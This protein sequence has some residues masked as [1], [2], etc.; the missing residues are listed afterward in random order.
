MACTS[1]SAL[2]YIKR[3]RLHLVRELQNLSVI[4]ENLYQQRVLSDE[5]VSKIQAEV[6]DYNKTRRILDSVMKNGEEACYK[7]LRIIDM[8]RKRAIGR[9]SL[10]PDQKTFISTE[11]KK[12]DLHHWISCFSFKEETKMETNYLQGSKQSYRYQDYLKSKA[13]KISRDFWMASKN[14]FEENKPDLSY[15]SLVL[16]TQKNISPSKIKILKSKKSRMSRPKKLKTY[17]PEDKPEISPSDLLKTDKNILLVGKPG[18][19]KTALSLEMFKVWAERDNE[20]L[21]Y[22]FYFD[23]R[24]MSETPKNLEDLLFNVFSEPGE[25]KEEV[26]QD[27]KN[28]V[29]IIFDGVTDLSSSVVKKLVDKDLLPD[30][31]IIITCRPEDEEDFFHWDFLRVEVKGFSEKTIKT[32]LSATLGEEQKKVSSNLEL[33]TLCHVP[34]YALMVAACF[35]SQQSAQPCTVTE[36]YIN[37]V[38]LSLQ[39]NSNRS[40]TKDLNSF[41]TNK[42]EEILS[43]AQVAFLATEGKTVNLTKLPCEDIC[44]LSFLKSLVVKVA[45]TET[46]TRYAFLHYTIQEFFAAVWLLKNPDKIKE[47]FQQCLT[48]DKKH[49]KHLIPFMC[50]LLNEKSPT[51]MK[52][53]I[54]AQELKTTSNWFFKEAINTFFSCLCEEEDTEDSGPDVDILFLCQCLYESQCPE[55]CIYFLEKLEY[56]LDLSEKTLD[57]YPCCAVSYVITQSKEKKIRLN[58][59]DVKVSDKGM[60]GLFGCLQ[61]VQWCDPLPRQLWKIFLLSEE[62]M[63]HMSLLRL[64]GNQLHLPVV[65]RRQLFERAVKVMKKITTKVNVCLYWDREAPDY[66]D[67]CESLLEAL[68]NISSLRFRMTYRD[69]GVKDQEQHHGTVEMEKKKL[70]MDLCR[71]A[72]LQRVESFHSVVDKLISLFSFNSSLHTI[73]LDL[74]EHFKSEGCSS[75]LPSLQSVFQ[76]GPRVWSINLSER[77][78]S[79]LLEVLKLQPEKKP[80]E[81]TGWSDEESEVRSF[82]QCLPYISQLSFMPQPSDPSEE[83]RFFANLFCAATEREQQTGEKIVELLSSVCTYQTSSLK[84]KWCDFLIDLYSE[85]KTGLRVL[86]SLLSVFQSAPRVW[87]INLSERKTSILLEV[88]KLQPEKK[89]V[90]LTGWSDEESEVRSFLQCLPYISQLSVR[91]WFRLSDQPRLFVNLL[92]AAAER[93]HQTGEKILELLSSVCTYQTFPLD[94]RHMNDDVIKYQ[95]VFLLDLFFHVKDCE[96]KTGLRVLPSL[97]SVFQSAPTVWFIDLSERKT[98]ILLEVLKLQLQKKPVKL[99]GWSD[100]ES[101]VRSFLQCLP[102]ISQLSFHLQS[103]NPSEETRILVNLFCAAA[104]RE[105]QTGEKIL[106]LLSSV[107]TYE[108]FFLNHSYMNDD[109]IKHQSDFLLDLFSHVKD[110]ETKTGLRVLPSL[111]SVFQSLPTVWFINLSERKTSILLEV[112]KL[113]PEKK[114]VKLTGRSDEESEVRSF[115]QCLPYISQLRFDLQSSNCSETTRIFGNLLCAAAE[116]E[117]QTGEKI[118]EL[119]SSVCTYEP[120]FWNHS[121][122]ND[123]DRKHQ[124]DFLLDLFSHVKD[125]ET[126]TGLRVL[127]SLLSV[128]QS[129]PRVW[130]INLSER[131]TSILLEV[132]KLQPEK[133]PVKLTGWSDEESEV[134]S[135][136]QCLPYISRLS[137]DLQSSNCLE[138]TRIFV[139]LYCAAA[140]REQQT[141]EKILE[142]LSSVCTYEP[143]FWNHSYMNDGDRKHQCDFL[144]DLF[145]HVKD[146]E[147]KT[148]LRVLPSLLS[149][150]QSAPRVW[151]INLSERKTSILL[152]VLKLQPE[153]K[154]V[155]LTGWSDEESEVR[156]FLQFL[157]YISQLSVNNWFKVSDQ[158]RIF[159]NLLCA[160]AE[161]EQQTGEKILE[162][163]S[164]VCTYQTFPLDERYMNDDH[165]EYQCDF[166]LDLFSHVKDCETKT[167]LRVL[168]SLLSVFQSAP[169]VWF[170]NLSERKTSILLEVLKLQ[171]E[172]KPVELTGWS[173]EESEV[174]SFL[175]CLPYIS[176]LSFDLQS[177]NR[178]ET[179]RIFVNLFCAA[180]E[181]E[182][183]TGEKILELLSSVC[184]YQTFPLEGRYMRDYVIKHQC[185]FL[186]DL[187]SHVKD[188]E[189]KTG[190]RVLPSLLSVFQSAPRVWFINLSE[191]KTSILLEVLKLQPE[192]KPVKLTGWSDEESEVRSFLQCLPYISQLSFYLQSSNRS[193]TT[194][195]FVNLFCAAAEREQQTGEKIL[196]LLS[197]VCTYK[198]FPLCDAYV[199]DYVLKSQSDYLLDL[200]SHVKDCET[201]TGL[202]VLPSFQ[203]VFQCV[204]TVWFIN[205]SERKTSILLEV[206]K[207]Q[208]EKKPVELTG[209]SDEESEVRSFLQCLPYISQLSFDLQ[210]SNRSKTTR[211]FGNLLCAAAEREQQTG[212]KILELLSSVCRYEIFFLNEEYM[213]DD[214]RKHQ[215]D[216]LLDLFSHVKDYETKTG[217]RVLSS[218]LSVFQSAPTVWFINL[219]E[220]KTSILLEVLK[221]QPEKKPV[222]LTGWSDEESEVRSFLQCLP[223]I[224]QLSFYPQSSNRSETTRIFVNLFCAAAEREQQTGEKILELLSSVCTY[225][226]FFWNHSYMNDGDRKHQSDFLLDLF[227]H[228]KD[229]ETKTGLRVLPS[230]LSVFQSAPTV[231]FINLLERKT[232]ILLEV[233]KLQPE[234]KPVKLTGWSDEES[235]VRS[236]LQCLPYISQLSFDLQSSNPSEKN[237]IFV[238]LFYAAAEREQQT[239]EKILELLSSVCTYQTFPLGDRG[240]N[241]DDREYQSDYLLDV[242]SHVKDCETKTGLR[243]LPSLLSVFQLVPTVWFINLLERKTSILLEVLK[244]QPEKKPVKLTGWSDEE[245]EVRSFLQCLPYISHST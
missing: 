161:R 235:E 191:R 61:N 182:Q 222:E 88:L 213:Y 195:I 233:L 92:C 140:E 214:D 87:S 169:R 203:S 153:K 86:P 141:G 158:T 122:M 69:P 30:A 39:M 31:K 108:P 183:Q 210:S 194:R 143:F 48:E 154:P 238:N 1:Q 121:Y 70:S 4:V 76:S 144:L 116:R 51:L 187:F 82:L 124:S 134:R 221:L 52:C 142:L 227:S 25:G 123:G 175:Q 184:T 234:K 139:N 55:A 205:L 165:K 72:A 38:R 36:I 190:L 115:L 201:K 28:N 53:L 75:V 105:Q 130:F 178:S 3:A 135:F 173:D 22:M 132:L 145:S 34:M 243:V 239:G 114:P 177:S 89:P 49:M 62:Q 148:G 176:Q 21:D 83:T 206:L 170:I 59:E 32:Y 152:E 13:L 91:R 23:M 24:Q 57:L 29:T 41:I 198:T 207:L 66:Q 85:T 156:S 102:Y 186:L 47:V 226:T 43:L 192:K 188:Y 63:D 172:K 44:V 223:Y 5:E 219:S 117:Q 95:C 78:T 100:E 199:D 202:R 231:W 162:L 37:I 136:L 42:S 7:F 65:G 218:L 193:E 73:L 160:A 106:E 110:C 137:F 220:R 33:L 101:E 147:T 212:E 71:K 133:K 241:D 99:T 12:F 20:E 209:W 96:T 225:Q 35:S 237:W 119:L 174:R 245:S 159:G 197:S 228:V 138:E 127:P 98:S 236:F 149:V 74:Y 128:F 230:L 9:P 185:D 232:S 50:R 126:K 94:D 155:E 67:L 224:S 129:A 204:P 163:L 15:T 113:Q 79:I 80:V 93:E 81:L 240:M 56:H 14:L 8:M 18:I 103:S 146:C 40:K 215:C 229:C 68:P 111:L 244:L 157:P 167:G 2:D 120:F 17:V 179:T 181:R 54:P 151:F 166:L 107:C 216:F 27:I 26:L 112:L 131:K 200:F 97:L 10:L 16:D 84:S 180:A 45:H 208:P 125:Y 6:Y 104:E 189:T 196:E 77:K 109:V 171:P 46:I 217:L 19:G 242:F 118:L 211:I 150:F 168:P 60:S 64:D 164:S 11:T 58:L 90:N